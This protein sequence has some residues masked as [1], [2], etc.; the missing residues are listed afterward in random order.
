M[1]F[2]LNLDPYLDE[3]RRVRSKSYVCL[4]RGADLNQGLLLDDL[5]FYLDKSFIWNIGFI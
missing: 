2:Y 4:E 1:G 5:G 3:S